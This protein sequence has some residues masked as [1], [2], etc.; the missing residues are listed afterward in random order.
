MTVTKLWVLSASLKLCHVSWVPEIAILYLKL[1]VHAFNYHFQLAIPLWPGAF[2]SVKLLHPFS[3]R[4]G[5]VGPPSLPRLR[6]VLPVPRLLRRSLVPRR[7]PVPSWQKSWNTRAIFRDKQVSEGLPPVRTGFHALPR[8]ALTF[9]P[10]SPSPVNWAL[11]DKGK[12]SEFPPS[13]PTLSMPFPGYCAALWRCFPCRSPVIAPLCGDVH[14]ALHE[15]F[16]M[17]VVS[18][19]WTYF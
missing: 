18:F 6:G 11:L 19:L 17:P 12:S 14:F 1:I 16:L 13:F 7:S 2:L 9:G 10:P 15:H 5:R 4:F 8:L 3:R